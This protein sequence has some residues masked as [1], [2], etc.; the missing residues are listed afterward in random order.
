MCGTYGKRGVPTGAD[1]AR[2]LRIDHALVELPGLAQS[3]VSGLQSSRPAS[4]LPAQP[5]S[6]YGSV[7]VP[8]G[9]YLAK[10]DNRED[11]DDPG[12]SGFV[13]EEFNGRA[14]F[15]ALSLDPARQR[16]SRPDRWGL[17]LQ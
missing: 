6:N 1:R 16:L 3:Q 15:V 4:A 12:F 10:G 11:S 7:T 17:A 5:V 13:R 8:A 9:H 2:V 14:R